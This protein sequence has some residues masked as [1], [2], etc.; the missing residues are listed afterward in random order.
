MFLSMS[1]NSS[2]VLRTPFTPIGCAGPYDPSVLTCD[3]S[4]PL[5]TS[6][7]A[8]C[9]PPAGTDDHY[10]CGVKFTGLTK[11]GLEH[12]GSW[13]EFVSRLYYDAVSPVT[14]VTIATLHKYIFDLD[15]YD[16]ADRFT[17]KFC[18]ST[19]TGNVLWNNYE[20][21]AVKVITTKQ[22]CYHFQQLLY[23]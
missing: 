17:E 7:D 4:W 9:P 11:A 15:V 14:G 20:H 1:T 21:P 8:I 10:L 23:M 18:P 6:T 13:N 3:L 2:A 16:A 12:Y 5:R 19:F 22:V